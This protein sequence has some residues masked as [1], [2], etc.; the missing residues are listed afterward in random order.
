MPVNAP[1]NRP[2]NM[3]INAAVNTAGALKRASFDPATLFGASDKGIIIDFSDATKLFQDTGATTPVT[4]LGDPIALAKDIGPRGVN[5]TQSTAANR[6]TR[7]GNPRTLGSELVTNGRF[8]VDANWNKGTGWTISG[9]VATK[10]AGS[11]ADL[12]QDI[13]LTAN[14]VYL[15]FFN[16]TRSA[17]TLTVALTGGTT[18]IG[19][20]LTSRNTN[21]SYVDMFIAQTGNTT[22]AFQADAS[23]A[24]TVFG[25]SVKEVTTFKNMG[26]FFDSVND[27]LATAAI[28]FSGSTTMSAMFSGFHGQDVATQRA[29]EVG[30]YSSSTAGSVMIQAGPNPRA[31]FRGATNSA[32]QSLPA[33]EAGGVSG[34]CGLM[35]VTGL[36]DSG[37]ATIAD[38]II[39]RNRGVKPTNTAAGT[40]VGGGNMVNGVVSIGAGTTASS[41]WQGPLNRVLVINRTLSGTDLT[42]AEA[43][44]KNGMVYAAVLGDSTTAILNSA[45][46]LPDRRNVSTFCS[47]L[48]CGGAAIAHSGDRIA[49]QKTAW[50]ALTT[51]SALEVVIVQIGLNDVKGRVGA[52]TATTAQVIADLQDLIT[53]IRADVPASCKIFVS[54]LTP[55]KL[56]LDAATDAAAA[57]QAW[58]DVNTAIAGGGATPITGVDGRI[59]S[60][61]ALLADVDGKS[62]NPIYEL[63]PSGTPGVHENNEGAFILA[64]AWRGALESAGI[65][66]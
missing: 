60:H 26:A 66:T 22:L 50:Q 17:G 13:T 5:A 10:A 23:F 28:D 64:Q 36:F 15:V 40:A 2:L 18:P 39:L 65:L 3:A 53:T 1:I 57:N 61:V 9:G 46:S 32:D 41:R 6:P 51:K 33:V 4:A 19:G 52:G 43:W 47:G 59:T 62:L 24:G 30:N 14:K 49:N 21:G 54:Q 29:L 38:Q 20:H 7:I 34:F 16:M 25:V 56:W 45:G 31:F 12:T 48:I 8:T 44:L 11:A 35:S 37:G 55:C 27:K 58:L 63:D 42:N